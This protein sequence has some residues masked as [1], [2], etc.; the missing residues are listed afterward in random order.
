M[1]FD[2]DVDADYGDDAR[3][4]AMQRLDRAAAHAGSDDATSYRRSF[5]HGGAV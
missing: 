2:G 4:D 1:R 3:D 5:G